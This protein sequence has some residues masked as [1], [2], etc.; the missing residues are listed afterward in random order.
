MGCVHLICA[1]RAACSIR[2]R[3]PVSNWLSTEHLNTRVHSVSG[4][5]LPLVCIQSER[6]RL[7][8]STGSGRATIS[9]RPVNDTSW[10]TG[11]MGPLAPYFILTSSFT[12]CPVLLSRSTGPDSIVGWSRFLSGVNSV[13]VLVTRDDLLPN[14]GVLFSISVTKNWFSLPG[15]VRLNIFPVG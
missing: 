5:V 2:A 1:H 6:D 3:R 8:R 15:S 13:E 14:T 10:P 4:I 12:G 7:F 11:P 9:N